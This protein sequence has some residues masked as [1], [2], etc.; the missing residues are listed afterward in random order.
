MKPEGIFSNGDLWY[1]TSETESG[2]QWFDA[3]K[4]ESKQESGPDYQ[5][6]EVPERFVLFTMTHYAEG[7]PERFA[8]EYELAKRIGDKRYG[9]EC[10]HSRT[11]RGYCPDCLRKVK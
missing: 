3:Y 8:Q 10:Q 1:G 7:T 2:Q 11:K 5:T 4:P 9:S 6:Q